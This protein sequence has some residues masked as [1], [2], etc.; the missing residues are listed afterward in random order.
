MPRNQRLT[1]SAIHEPVRT[2]LRLD[3]QRGAIGQIVEV[4]PA[5]DFRL[6][7]I[8]IDKVAQINMRSGE[9]GS[10]G[11]RPVRH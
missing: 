10:V 6:N 4:D 1:F 5:L 8:V 7:D 11:L 9:R 3:F 2:V